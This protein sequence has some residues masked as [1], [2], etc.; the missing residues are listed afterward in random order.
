MEQLIAH[1]KVSYAYV[2]VT[3]EDLTPALARHLHLPVSHGAIVDSVLA[4]SPGD[5]AGLQGA[6]RR[7]EFNGTVFGRGGDVIVAIDGRTVASAEDVI[8]LVSGRLRPG[9]TTTFTIVRGGHRRDVPVV[10]AA[11]PQNPHSGG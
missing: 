1:G 5:K 11:R 7:E 2:G 6:T 8:R 4:G 3:T 9:Q 10:L